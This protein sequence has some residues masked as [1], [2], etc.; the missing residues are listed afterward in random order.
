MNGFDV[1]ATRH[2]ERA[3][4]K[5]ARAHP[6]VGGEYEAVLPILNADPYNRTRRH[7]IRKLEG[8]AAGEGQ[9]RIRMRRF[10]FIY[11]IDGRTVFLKACALRR[12]DTY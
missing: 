6:Q 12:E 9:Y 1:R 8:V 7:A 3:L 2:F 10:R 4:K 11:D 5:L